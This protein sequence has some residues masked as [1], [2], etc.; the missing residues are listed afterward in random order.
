M[1]TIIQQEYK[2]QHTKW[3]ATIMFEEFIQ[4]PRTWKEETS[5]SPS[6]RHSGIYKALL[7]VYNNYNAEF[8][9]KDNNGSTP[10]QKA[11]AIFQII[12]NLANHVANFGFFLQ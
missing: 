9:N 8:S 1:L 2:K 6:G 3:K 12:C 5:I 4:G 7:T 11:E 10:Q